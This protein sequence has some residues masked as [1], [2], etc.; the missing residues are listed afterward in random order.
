MDSLCH[1]DSTF[2]SDLVPSG[3]FIC[4]V[5]F[6]QGPCHHQHLP[7]APAAISSDSEL[8]VAALGLSVRRHWRALGAPQGLLDK[9]KGG[10]K[11]EKCENDEFTRSPLPEQL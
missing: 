10:R 11:C 1:Y 2:N 3:W 6:W 5:R 8:V 4:S 7:L 9:P